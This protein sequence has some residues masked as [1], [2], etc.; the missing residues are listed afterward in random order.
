MTLSGSHMFSAYDLGATL[1]M[2]VIHRKVPDIVSGLAPAPASS[3]VL[4]LEAALHEADVER[5][6]RILAGLLKD[7]RGRGEAGP[8]LFIRPRSF[9]MACRLRAMDGITRVDGLILTVE[10]EDERAKVAGE[11]NR[12]HWARI[13]R[14]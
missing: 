10:A 14:D 9:D 8:R 4:C 2:P 1:Y 6:V 3:I 7:G 13:W 5:G 12:R 11:Q